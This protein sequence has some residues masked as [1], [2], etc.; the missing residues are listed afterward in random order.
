[1][2]KEQH[3]TT[4]RPGLLGID[5]KKIIVL[6]KTNSFNEDNPV[7]YV[8]GTLS[9]PKYRS[10][11]CLF[12]YLFILFLLFLMKGKHLESNTN[13][14]AFIEILPRIHLISFSF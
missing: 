11:I 6:I 13:H 14:N 8:F 10:I 4:F 5:W 9:Y 3:Q 12:V 7:I 2:Q 1:M